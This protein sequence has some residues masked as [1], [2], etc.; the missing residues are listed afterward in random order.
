MILGRNANKIKKA[1]AESEKVRLVKKRGIY[2]LAPK[3]CQSAGSPA[4]GAGSTASGSRE[5]S[6]QDSSSKSLQKKKAKQ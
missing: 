2:W 5:A 6:S 4:K 1:L 3:L